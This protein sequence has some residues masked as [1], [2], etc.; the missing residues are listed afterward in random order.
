MLTNIRKH[1]VG[2][3]RETNKVINC[4]GYP[5]YK[6]EGYPDETLQALVGLRDNICENINQIFFHHNKNCPEH[7]R[8][9]ITGVYF[10]APENHQS[11]I[12]NPQDFAIIISDAMDNGSITCGKT[13]WAKVLSQF[14]LCDGSMLKANTW[15]A[16]L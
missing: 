6:E 10:T 2:I 1:E 11:L 9:S 15:R 7:K 4:Q 12:K 5:Q 16:Y 8:I 13:A 14:E 3:E